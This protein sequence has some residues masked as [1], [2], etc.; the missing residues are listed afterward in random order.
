[1]NAIFPAWLYRVKKDVMKRYKLLV[2]FLF[3]PVCAVIAQPQSFF[4]APGQIIRNGTVARGYCLERFKDVLGLGNLAELTKITGNVKAIYANGREQTISL[5]ELLTSKRIMLI[6]HNSY[7]F[8]QFAF[9]DN[10]I[11][12]LEIGGE[13]ISLFREKMTEHENSLAVKNIERILELESLGKTHAEIQHIIW[14]TRIEKRSEI[15]S[16][17]LVI[18]WQTTDIEKEK[19]KTAFN[20]TPTVSFGKNGSSFMRID[21]LLNNAAG[22]NEYV[23]EL[24]THFHSDHISRPVVEQCIKEG[25]FIR[26]IAPHPALDVSRN[27]IFSAIEENTGIK[28]YNFRQENRVLEIVPNG[29]W[30]SLNDTGVIGDFYYSRFAVNEDTTVKMYKYK[31]P[32]NANT[33]GLIYLFTHKNVSTLVFG[34][35]DDMDGIENLLV[36]SSANEKRYLEIQENISKLTVQLLEA[37]NKVV[38]ELRAL[39][40]LSL[41][42]EENDAIP[43]HIKEQLKTIEDFDNK[44]HLLKYELADLHFLKADVIKWMHHAHID[45]SVRQ[46]EL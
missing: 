7:E 8:L 33:D 23:I 36:A 42:L 31:K 21:G 25:S 10:T 1:M 26:L 22:I 39:A 40:P 34:D 38:T 11:A 5:D 46:T 14:R 32:H 28:E 3:F 30:L 37:Q 19:V 24:I 41:S 6:P 9:L 44:I 35:F 16:K 13:G 18:D 12:S 15:P 4:V 17:Q 20:S 43:Q 2:F 29:R 27:R 45:N